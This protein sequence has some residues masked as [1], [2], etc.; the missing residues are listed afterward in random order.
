MLIAER[1]G[2]KTNGSNDP[3][4]GGGNLFVSLVTTF[5]VGVGVF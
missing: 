2:I 4:T 1:I 5:C 3:V